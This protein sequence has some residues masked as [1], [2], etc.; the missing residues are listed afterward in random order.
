MENMYKSIVR[1]SNVKALF[2]F[3]VMVGSIMLAREL[4]DEDKRLLD[5]INNYKPSITATKNWNLQHVVWTRRII[6]Y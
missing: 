3:V 6:Y 5:P 2:F 4:P 1:K